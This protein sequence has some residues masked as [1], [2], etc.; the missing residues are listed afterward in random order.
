MTGG[1]NRHTIGM[2]NKRK[3]IRF[4]WKNFICGSVNYTFSVAPLFI[5]A[6]GAQATNGA[7]NPV[8]AFIAPTVAWLGEN[9][10]SVILGSI[11]KENTYI[12]GDNL[13]VTRFPQMSYLGKAKIIYID[14]SYNNGSDALLYGDDSYII[15]PR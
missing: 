12:E 11:D 2:G 8:Y 7:V 1:N 6:L 14:P 13:D 3:K 4:D 5:A 9:V 10:K 15:L